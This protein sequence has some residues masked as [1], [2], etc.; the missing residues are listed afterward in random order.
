MRPLVGAC[1]S[2]TRRPEG[3]VHA[4]SALAGNGRL[5]VI[6]DFWLIGHCAGNTATRRIMYWN[7]AAYQTI[8]CR[9]DNS[10]YASAQWL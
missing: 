7:Y 3:G 6:D 2:E 10:Y 1:Y 4:A 8:F 9:Q 5:F